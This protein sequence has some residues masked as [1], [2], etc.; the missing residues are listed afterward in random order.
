MTDMASASANAYLQGISDG[1]IASASAMC[2]DGL[3]DP[4]QYR[5]FRTVWES[6][7]EEGTLRE[8]GKRGA[9]SNI[10][11]KT[12]VYQAHYDFKGTIGLEQTVTQNLSGGSELG[13]N[14]DWRVLTRN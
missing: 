9:F 11:S 10:G 1:N 14:P 12:N 8:F 7:G 3:H 4:Q 13:P 2:R 5:A 6:G